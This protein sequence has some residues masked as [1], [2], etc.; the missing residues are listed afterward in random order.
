MFNL[1]YFSKS[2]LAGTI[3][4]KTAPKFLGNFQ[5]ANGN[6]WNINAIIGNYVC[7]C[8]LSELHPYFSN[9]SSFCNYGFIE[10]TWKPYAIEII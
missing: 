3:N 2:E 10:Q 9:T 1:S 8:K 4:C 7:A 5:D 6:T